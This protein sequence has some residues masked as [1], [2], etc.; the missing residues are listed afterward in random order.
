[1]RIF[2]ILCGSV[3]LRGVLAKSKFIL[4]A[5]NSLKV[6]ARLDHWGGNPLQTDLCTRG[7]VT[8]PHLLLPRPDL[9]CL[10]AVQHP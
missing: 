7:W 2:A 10:F 3:V 4:V 9:T 6:H 8:H 5:N 1:M